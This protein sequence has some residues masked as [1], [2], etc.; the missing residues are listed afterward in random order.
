M[1]SILSLK[2]Y[3]LPVY[4]VMLTGRVSISRPK[5]GYFCLILF[6]LPSQDITENY[7]IQPIKTLNCLPAVD[8]EYEYIYG[9]PVY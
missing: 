5:N 1:R 6:C 3:L 4:I 8:D 9:R 7:E 2:F